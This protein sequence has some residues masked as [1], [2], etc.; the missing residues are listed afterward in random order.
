MS[1]QQI[2]KRLWLFLFFD[3][4]IQLLFRVWRKVHQ[5]SGRATAACEEPLL[6]FCYLLLPPEAI[7]HFHNRCRCWREDEEEQKPAGGG[8]KSPPPDQNRRRTS[9]KRK[10]HSPPRLTVDFT[11]FIYLNNG[12]L[13]AGVE[14]PAPMS[15]DNL[16][17]GSVWPAVAADT[18]LPVH[19]SGPRG[20][21]D[22]SLEATVP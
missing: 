22:G 5:D 16:D 10:L 9:T 6:A 3:K 1:A 7:S 17:K 21:T 18:G 15:T 2:P 20:N 14:A 12:S 13:R 11:P 4:H 8:R 19:R